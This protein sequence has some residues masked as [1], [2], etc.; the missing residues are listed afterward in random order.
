M[1]KL[2]CVVGLVA[3]AM[4]ALATTF[5]TETFESYNVGNL[6]P[7]DSWVSHSGQTGIPV[8]VILDNGPTYP[9][10]KAI[11][12]VHGGS[13]RQDVNK[14]LGDTMAAGDKWY[15][16]FDVKVTG[17]IG[18]SDY[19]A[20]FLQG[21]SNFG[22][23]TGVAAFED[24]FQ[25][26]LTNGSGSTPTQFWATKLA[27]GTWYRVI[28]SYDFDSGMSELW[29]DP[30]DSSSTKIS[31]SWFAGN[32]MTAYAFRQGGNSTAGQTVDNVI[33]GTSFAEVLPEPSSI[34]LLALG[35]LLRR[36]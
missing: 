1:R 26:T 2:A 35:L 19:F 4:P 11:Y 13:S 32:A 22:A 27:L 30:I 3:L 8:A 33:V 18:G 23:K 28:T 17:P 34:M 29:V 12:A 36:R 25:F 21:T 6:V 24:G 16:G 14:P 7:Q 10:E 20:H 31:G 15:A 5:W 9:G